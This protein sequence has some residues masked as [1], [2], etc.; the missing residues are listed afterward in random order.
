MYDSLQISMIVAFFVTLVLAF[1]VNKMITD[2]VALQIGL[3]VGEWLA[4]IVMIE[5]LVYLLKVYIDRRSLS[6]ARRALSG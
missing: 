1:T 6:R 2:K 3:A 4:M 5:L